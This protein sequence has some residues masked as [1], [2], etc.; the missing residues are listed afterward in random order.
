MPAGSNPT[1]VTEFITLNLFEPIKLEPCQ[2]DTI[3]LVPTLEGATSES[4]YRLT[5]YNDL[6]QKVP[7]L[8]VVSS[9]YTIDCQTLVPFLDFEYGNNSISLVRTIQDAN[10]TYRDEQWNLIVGKCQETKAPVVKSICEAQSYTWNNTPYTTTTQKTNVYKEKRGNKN[11]EI[12]ESLNLTV[13]PNPEFEVFVEGRTASIETNSDFTLITLDNQNKGTETEFTWLPVG[14]H[15]IKMTD[16]NTCSSE[17]SFSIIPKPLAP[18]VFFTPNDDTQN[19]K[20]LIDGI[21]FYP[22]AFIQIYDRYS[23]LL[24]TFRGIDFEGWDGMYNGHPMPMDDYWYVIMIPETKQQ[25][26]G[27]FVLKR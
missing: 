27:H 18:M 9:E 13:H 16:I 25:I 23:R 5:T 26:S 3:T 6:S 8:N 14:D 2:F 12:T 7:L 22:E 15:T 24:K 21:E 4:W 19:D 20:W 1:Q 10:G 11:W 17:K